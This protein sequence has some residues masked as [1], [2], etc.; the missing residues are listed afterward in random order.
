[1][2]EDKV[3]TLTFI[4]IFTMVL[5][6]IMMIISNNAGV[7]FILGLGIFFIGLSCIIFSAMLSVSKQIDK[8]LGDHL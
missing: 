7:G 1:M 2:S 6:G 8:T 5:G 3:P 4:I